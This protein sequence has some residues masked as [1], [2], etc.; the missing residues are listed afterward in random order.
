MTALSPA[1]GAA[2]WSRRIAMR[3]PGR[4]AVIDGARQVTYA[5]LD[6]RVERLAVALSRRGVEQG[7]RIAAVLINGLP[8]IELYLAAA[9]LGAILLPVNWRLAPPE[10]AWIIDNAE[11][12][13]IFLSESLSNLVDPSDSAAPMLVVPDQP[14]DDDAYEALIASVPADARLTEDPAPDSD[15]F[16]LYTSGTTGRPKGCLLPQYGQVIAAFAMASQWQIDGHARLLI[17]LPLFH[18]GG[19]GLLFAHLAVGACLVIAPRLFDADKAR[20]MASE[21]ECTALA[22]VP[23]LYPQLIADQRRDPLPLSLRRV[24]M[25]GGM[26]APEL[27]AEV[28]EVLG[29]EP[30]LGYG[31][32]EAGN[33]IAYLMGSEQLRHPKACGRA[34]P[35]FDFRAVDE[36]DNPLPLGAT[37]ELCVRG[38]SLLSGY[39]RNPEATAATVRDG[40]LHTGDL[41]RLDEHGLLTLVGRAKEL[42]KTGGENVY[43]REVEAV[44]LEHPAIADC[45]VFGVP[46]DYWGEAVKTMIALRPGHSLDGAGVV[47]WVRAR[48]AGYK[49]PRFVEF[50]PALPRTDTGKL[51]TRELR[52]R[53]V[54][55]D[56]HVD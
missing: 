35:Q 31:Q 20:R 33:Y 44:L 13:L 9:R 16:M 55:P 2:A 56:Q 41:V 53:P 1:L 17:S 36:N 39:W 40:W 48:I 43:P 18:V 50:V 30:I 52:A 38:P 6:L 42:I 11:P 22:V 14:G 7:D 49:R 45:V 5:E 34:I 32:T 29:A 54:T 47:A 12:R 37:G 27:V 4:P 28:Q 10:I 46:H 24:T 21:L 19:T 26:H 23:Q 25:G 8:L 15:W 3:F 51:L